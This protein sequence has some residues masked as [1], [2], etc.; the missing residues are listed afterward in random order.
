MQPLVKFHV[1]YDIYVASG[2]IEMYSKCEK[3]NL[4]K[5]LFDR[6]NGQDQDI[7]CWNSM[8]VGLSLNNLDN[9]ALIS[10]TKLSSLS[11]GRQMH[12]HVI[13]HEIVNDG[14]VGSSLIDMYS[15]CGDVN[16]ARLVLDTML[17]KNMI[18]WNEKIH[19][20][21]QNGQ[22]E[23]GVS[24]YE[25]TIT[26]SSEKLKLDAITFIAV[27]TACSHSG[28]IDYGIKIVNSVFQEHG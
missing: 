18:I 11:H 22:G 9:D 1:A 14:V 25:E 15:K 21:T 19:G 26:N 7:V 28:L 16:D 10:C 6:M 23:K 27:L 24:L 13:K 12:A 17:K 2:L 5:I 4:A 8:L 20:Y 3:I